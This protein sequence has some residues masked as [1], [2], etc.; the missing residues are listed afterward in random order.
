MDAVK[1]NKGVGVRR[2]MN[3]LAPQGIP[4]HR[5]AYTRTKIGLIELTRSV[6]PMPIFAAIARVLHQV[7]FAMGA[8]GIT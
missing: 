3:I 4:P 2:A 7:Q 1:S 8:S 6:A 5:A